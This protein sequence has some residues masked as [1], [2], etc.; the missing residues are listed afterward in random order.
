MI[1][2]V[3]LLNQNKK[4]KE[5]I[6]NYNPIY[7]KEYTTKFIKENIQIDYLNRYLNDY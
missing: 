1:L 7:S 5:I 2:D 6:I 3:F 4:T